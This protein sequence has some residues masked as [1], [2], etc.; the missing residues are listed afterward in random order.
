[1]LPV[2]VG[3]RER[4]RERQEENGNPRVRADPRATY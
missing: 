3:A 1:M 2:I 4:G